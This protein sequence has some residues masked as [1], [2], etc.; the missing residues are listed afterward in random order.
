M[1]R[2]SQNIFALHDW[3]PEVHDRVHA[4]KAGDKDA[5]RQIAREM[6]KAISRSHK[7]LVPM[8]SHYGPAR[9][10]YA[11]A[12]Q[13]HKRTTGKIIWQCLQCKPRASQCEIKKSGG[14]L[15]GDAL[16]F[17]SY[18][19]GIDY[20]IIEDVIGTGETAKA[21][22]KAMPGSIVLSYAVDL[23]TERI[24]ASENGS[25]LSSRIPLLKRLRELAIQKI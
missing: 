18:E 10:T 14:L 23:N 24:S 3:T 21:A 16:G 1:I 9:V 22:L 13:I 7:V 4:A 11:I 2:L 17:S 12:Q 6:A 15:V 19:C 5:I 20:L 8:P 25:K